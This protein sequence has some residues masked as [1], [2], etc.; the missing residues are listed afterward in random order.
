LDCAE[1]IDEGSPKPIDGAGH[2]NMR[3]ATKTKGN[4]GLAASCDPRRLN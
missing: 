4:D 2:H 1:E 3:R